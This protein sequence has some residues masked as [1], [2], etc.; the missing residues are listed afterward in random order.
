MSDTPGPTMRCTVHGTT[1]M[2]P[3]DKCHHGT[4]TP[5]DC[6]FELEPID[7]P[8]QPVSIVVGWNDEYEN[9]YF[10][11]DSPDAAE[12]DAH[13][14]AATVPALLW[15]EFK[16][17][18]RAYSVACDKIL[19]EAGFDSETGH[20]A[21]CC[22]V[23]RGHETPSRTWFHVV[24]A[25]ADDE[26]SWPHRDAMLL[27]R[28]RREDAQAYIDTLPE[29]LTVLIPAGERFQTIRRADLRIEEGGFRGSSS[30]CYRC[31]WSRSEHAD[32]GSAEDI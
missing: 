1:F 7:A 24:L 19:D 26:E 29:E 13:V 8:D 25:A 2:G 14:Y 4:S 23:W 12:D 27:S 10:Y 21:K 32:Q 28:D 17:A 30:E 9:A 15:R 6:T 22:D 11:E 3:D 16:D 31:G 18:E 20:L 5:G